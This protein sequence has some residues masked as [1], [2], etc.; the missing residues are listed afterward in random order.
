MNERSFVSRSELFVL[1]NPTF[2]KP[3]RG[4]ALLRVFLSFSYVFHVFYV[5]VS[6]SDNL[7]KSYISTWNVFTGITQT[8]T[9]SET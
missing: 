6:L 9:F 1:L 8:L 2:N 3:F 5:L 7:H 4:E